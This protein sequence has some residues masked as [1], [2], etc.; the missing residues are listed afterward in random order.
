VEIVL[1]ELQARAFMLP[2][3]GKHRGGHVDAVDVRGA[4]LEKPPAIPAFT[5]AY[6]QHSAALH[7]F[8]HH[9]LPVCFD[10]ERVGRPVDV[11]IQGPQAVA[12][13]GEVSL[14]VRCLLTCH[15][16][17]IHLADSLCRPVRC[18]SD[19]WSTDTSPARGESMSASAVAWTRAIHFWHPSFGSSRFLRLRVGVIS[20]DTPRAGRSW[21]EF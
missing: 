10:P 9:A 19:Q 17:G 11:P 7:G 20:D 14:I 21:A 8:S 16:L 18:R 6:F 4:P 13:G 2:R 15:S 1:E 5:A 12:S 3:G